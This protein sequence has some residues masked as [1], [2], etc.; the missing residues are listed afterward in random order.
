MS[1]KDL[2]EFP[3]I[4]LLTAELEKG[5]GVLLGPGDDAAMVQSPASGATL[6][7]CDVSVEGVHFLPSADPFDIGYKLMTANISDIAA[8]GG[9][10]LYALITLVLPAA[11]KVSWVDLL[12]NGIRSCAREYGVSVVGG[13]VSGG[14]S[15][16]VSAT[17]MGSVDPN[18]ALMRSAAKPGDVVMVSGK[19][20]AAQVGLEIHSGKVSA[21]GPLAQAALCRHLRPVPRL[22]LAQSLADAGCRSANDIS[23]GLASEAW[24]I[25]EASG[26]AICIDASLMPVHP[27]VSL[28][29][30]NSE[31]ALAYALYS[32][33]E[34][35]LVFT[36]PP[37]VLEA[38]GDVLEGCVRIGTVL[39]GR[40]AYL[41]SDGVT[42]PLG[43][44]HVHFADGD[45]TPDKE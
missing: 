33:E 37:S 1:I 29:A 17:L 35:E 18:R 34:Y 26:V 19:L 30:G 36:I 27:S 15:I 28:V 16:V 24:E 11:T 12:Y 38:C 42:R 32:G 25:A 9:T 10:P 4:A 44:G 3:L 23:D 5:P 6:L 2:G 22:D 39:A 31:S 14:S 21:S 45:A 7:T 8:M 13:D 43:R 41:L 40:G 20:G